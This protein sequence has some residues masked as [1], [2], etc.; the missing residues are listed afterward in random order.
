M[1]Y[2]LSHVFQKFSKIYFFKGEKSR[3][4]KAST[5]YVNI[6]WAWYFCEIVAF[7]WMSLFSGLEF[8]QKMWAVFAKMS[9]L[10]WKSQ[11]SSQKHDDWG[12]PVS[13]ESF[14]DVLYVSVERRLTYLFPALFNDRIRFFLKNHWNCDLHKMFEN[15]LEK[16]QKWWWLAFRLQAATSTVGTHHEGDRQIW[17]GCRDIAIQSWNGQC[18]GVSWSSTI[19]R[20]VLSSDHSYR[21]L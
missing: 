14:T 15:H 4:K 3:I 2:V 17:Y 13:A 9:Y 21:H 5:V 7:G 11:N 18:L 8:F 10:C 16:F 12:L 19:H 1:S 20:G 6:T